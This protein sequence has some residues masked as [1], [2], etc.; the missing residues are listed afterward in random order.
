MISETEEELFKAM[1]Y[2][3]YLKNQ[4]LEESGEVDVKMLKNLSVNT[5]FNYA[6]RDLNITPKTG[7]LEECMAA[8]E[9]ICVSFYYFN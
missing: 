1:K 4:A 6:D 2:A 5:S 8:F 3:N 7:E 9:K